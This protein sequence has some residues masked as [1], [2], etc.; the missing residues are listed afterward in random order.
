MLTQLQAVMKY[1]V[2]EN[3]ISPSIQVLKR[4]VVFK[5][6]NDDVNP[7]VADLCLVDTQADGNIIKLF[8]DKKVQFLYKNLIAFIQLIFVSP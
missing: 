2:T 4:K 1:F 6:P 7:V 3:Q 5:P 8:D